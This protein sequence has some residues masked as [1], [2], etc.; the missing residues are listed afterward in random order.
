MLRHGSSVYHGP[1]NTSQVQPSLQYLSAATTASFFRS[2]N[3]AVTYQSSCFHSKN[4]WLKT[5]VLEMIKLKITQHLVH[6]SEEWRREWELV[7]CAGSMMVHY[8][9][10]C[11]AASEAV[12]TAVCGS[13]Y[14]QVIW[15]LLL[16]C[17]VPSGTSAA[18]AGIA[19]VSK[20]L[21]M[22]TN[23]I[24]LAAESSLSTSCIFMHCKNSSKIFTGPSNTYCPSGKE[25]AMQ[26]C[27]S[28]Y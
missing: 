22:S 1:Q 27:L 19:L 21:V 25:C 16:L 7:P 4:A 2:G 18:T 26:R 28:I 8:C 23:K 3:V 10:R 17:L 14:K 6:E 12:Q 24:P 5:G 20:G 15:N 13:S 11:C 9:W